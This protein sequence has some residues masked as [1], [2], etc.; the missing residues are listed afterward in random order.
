MN[1]RLT[2]CTRCVSHFKLF[3]LINIL[4]LFELINILKLMTL[5]AKHENMLHILTNNK[6][7]NTFLVESKIKNR[8]FSI[9]IKIFIFPKVFILLNIFYLALH[10]RSDFGSTVFVKKDRIEDYAIFSEI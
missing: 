9:S 3:Q 1:K 7:S 2:I 5:K 8:Q 6:L 10:L 4:K